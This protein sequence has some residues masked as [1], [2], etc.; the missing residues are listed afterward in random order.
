M[1]GANLHLGYYDKRLTV[2]ILLVDYT[3]AREWIPH[4]ICEYMH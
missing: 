3:A 1:M 2:G 4:Y